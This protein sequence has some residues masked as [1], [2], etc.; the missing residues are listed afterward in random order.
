M[1]IIP[2]V[3][4]II[5]LLVSLILPGVT[6]GQ[7]PTG[8]RY[9]TNNYDKLE[10]YI[11]MRD[12]ARLFTS[13]YVP[14]NIS[15]KYPILLQRTPYSVAPYGPD[16]KPQIGPSSLFAQNGYIIVYQ[17]VRGRMMSEGQFEAVRPHNP[18][19]RSENDIDE[20]TD[21]YDTIAWLLSNLSGH[22]GRVGI[23]GIS[24]PGF[25]ATHALINAH[26]AVKI[27]SPQAPVTDWWLGDDRHHNGA[28][29][30]QASFSFLSFYGQ[31]RPSPTTR[32]AN[33]FRDYGTPDGYRWYLDL[34]PLSNVNKKYLHGK[35]EIWNNM[36]NHPDYDD[37]W[38]AR[39]PLPHLKGIKP[40]VL[41]VGGFFDAQDLYGPLKTYSAVETNNPGTVNHLVMGPWSHGGW[42]RG[43]GQRYQDINF[44]QPTAIYYREAIELP[45]FNH[46]LKDEPDPGLPEASIFVTGSNQWHAFNKWPPEKAKNSAIYLAPNGELSFDPPT[47]I[48]NYAEYVSD[49]EKPV[50]HTPKIVIS[51]DDR[52]LIQDQRF[53]S[54]RTDVLV[55]KSE[56]LKEDRT[57]TGDLFAHLYVATTGEDADFIVKL[58]DV[59]PD[60]ALYVGENPM[61]VKMGGFQLM[62]RGEVM[63]ARYR[64]SFTNPQPMISGKITK[65]EFDMQDVAHTFKVGHRIMV[66]IQSTWFPMVD[67]NPQTWVPN[68]YKAEKEDYK[69]AVHRVY[70]SRNAPSHLRIKILE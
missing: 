61:N 41:V 1:K 59:Y 6:S 19:K 18:N 70:F 45:F 60:S 39:T 55:F 25:Y 51:R 49:P 42:S 21:T 32:R 52:Y 4:F 23:W 14:K 63:R 22:N 8:T 64:N 69:A 15:K 2:Q 67:R 27:V 11:P 44:D 66:Q 50:P 62:V 5:V 24:A 7:A 48:N 29:Q 34:G 57:V 43:T 68:I 65:V 38:Q 56:I 3:P 30:L 12:G 31:P 36:V 9:I 54:S 53:A 17:D 26:P 37:F 33:G 47:G 13:I 20:S 16:F 10:R 40:A 46:Y 58:I 35:N 28:F